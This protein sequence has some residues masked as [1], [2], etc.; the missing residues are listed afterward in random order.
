MIRIDQLKD[1][2]PVV[3]QTLENAFL[4]QRIA[5]GYLFIG[6]KGKIM[7]DTAYLLAKCI[8]SSS[9][10]LTFD[11]NV[12]RRMEEGNFTDFI[13]IDGSEKSIKKEQILSLQEQ[14]SKTSL[15]A[16][17]KKVYIINACENATSEAMNSLLKFLEEPSEDT[18]AILITYAVDKVLDT[19]ISR[20][21]NIRFKKADTLQITSECE[22][23][24]V[25]SE[26]AN[27]IGRMVNDIST[28]Q[29]IIKQ[30]NYNEIKSEAL[31]LISL[32]QKEE[33]DL[34][35]IELQ[36]FYKKTSKAYD[37]KDYILLLRIIVVFYQEMLL[38]SFKG[39]EMWEKLQEKES[40]KSLKYANIVMDTIDECNV[41]I[42]LN[43]LLD[44]MIY[45]MKRI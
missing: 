44:R 37:R 40:K 45:K 16:Y 1:R 43:L 29:E 21:Q 35:G 19:I 24:G 28:I 39:D 26:D 32:F 14:F 36:L 34:A 5:Q 38:K 23:Q 13:L 33:L 30:E 25:P 2:Q 6:E 41:G 12:S 18:Y 9:T 4:H 22:M 17:G 27:I 11:E 8:I 7:L 20:C 31:E 15:E 42:N 3:Y 10:S